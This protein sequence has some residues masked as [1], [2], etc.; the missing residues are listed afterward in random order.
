[1]KL[2][3]WRTTFQSGAAS[4]HWRPSLSLPVVAASCVNFF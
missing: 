4:A 1:M 3:W 2:R